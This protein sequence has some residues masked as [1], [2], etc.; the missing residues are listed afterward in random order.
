MPPYPITK[1]TP[2]SWDAFVAAHP[3]AHILQTPAWANHKSHFGWS[4]E[5]V[6]LAAD[7]GALIAGAQL[8]YRPLPL[9]LGTLAYIPKGPLAP[10]NWWRDATTM[11]PL[12][13]A[14]HAAARRRG[15][16]WLKVEAPDDPDQA[17]LIAAL[18]AAGFRS[19]PQNVQPPRTIVL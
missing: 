7:D 17:V 1:P 14:I 13:Q 6:A 18:Q 19:S 2:E 5:I 11:R 3:Q 12:W 10:A 9:G 4:G 15:A 16:R 8:L